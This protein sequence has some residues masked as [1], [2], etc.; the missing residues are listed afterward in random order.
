LIT[1]QG[2]PGFPEKPAMQLHCD[3]EVLPGTENVLEGQGS[4]LAFVT[5]K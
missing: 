2:P 5:G 1:V 3:D 4:H